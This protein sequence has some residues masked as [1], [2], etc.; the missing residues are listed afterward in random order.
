[1]AEHMTAMVV[2]ETTG[3]GTQAK[4][5]RAIGPRIGG[6]GLVA[7]ILLALLIVGAAMHE[8]GASRTAA[9]AT[10]PVQTTGVAPLP[11]YTQTADGQ[12]VVTQVRDDG[13]VQT[14][15]IGSRSPAA[16]TTSAETRQ[17]G[18]T[19][20]P[21]AVTA[22]EHPD[23]TSERQKFLDVN[24]AWLPTVAAGVT[25]S[26]A[27]PRAWE[28]NTTTP[29]VCN[30]APAEPATCYRALPNGGS[31]AAQLQDDGTWRVIAM[32]LPTSEVAVTMTAPQ[33]AQKA[34]TDMICSTESTDRP[35]CYTFLPDG[36]KVLA[37]VPLGSTGP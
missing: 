29:T 2:E 36:T 31:Q 28:E 18:R 19:N 15:L 20:L 30:Y 27:M 37:A 8:R 23:V 34:S 35:L 1:M 32:W 14:G 5:G 4:R 26:A 3:I 16:V 24:S 21:D 7:A 9:P 17:F 22:A 33:A 13:A 25:Q 12:W 10:S 6:Y 11:A